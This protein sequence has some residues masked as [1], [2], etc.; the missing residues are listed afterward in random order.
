MLCAKDGYAFYH[1]GYDL[2]ESAAEAPHQTKAW[3]RALFSFQVCNDT[4]VGQGK[5]P[6]SVTS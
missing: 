4:K 3:S 1:N 5:E 6:L 2:G